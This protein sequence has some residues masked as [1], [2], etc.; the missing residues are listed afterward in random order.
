M[1]DYSNMEDLIFF[2]G[3]TYHDWQSTGVDVSVLKQ[4]Y[5]T[6]KWAPTSTNGNPLRIIFLQS[7]AEKDRVLPCLMPANIAQTK[8]AP[9]CAILAYDMDFY[10]K[11]DFLSPQNNAKSW[12]EGNEAYTKESAVLN[13][14]LQ[15]G[16]FILAARACHLD[17]GPMSG[18]YNDKVDQEF[19]SGT[20][21]K[22]LMLCNLGY[23]KKESL[24]PRAERLDFDDACKVL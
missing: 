22:S 17:C 10:K 11:L 13:A 1:S 15:A 18:F 24:Y 7:D 2:N 4:V 8:S 5:D 16:Y 23:G 14:S 9:I 19:F 20:S 21:Y 3:R 6:M 12:F